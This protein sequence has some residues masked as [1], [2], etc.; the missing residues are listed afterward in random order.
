MGE[1]IRNDKDRSVYVSKMY[2]N[3][4]L[5]F[6]VSDYVNSTFIMTNLTAEQAYALHDWIAQNVTRP[7][8]P[9]ALEQFQALRVGAGFTVSGDNDTRIKV[10]EGSY[11]NVDTR[12]VNTAE[13]FFQVHDGL[14]VTEE[15]L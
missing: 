8:A 15:E 3:E 12:T 11:Y 2:F 5:A 10:S 14:T 7:V 1:H 9:T 4:T 13:T 6:D